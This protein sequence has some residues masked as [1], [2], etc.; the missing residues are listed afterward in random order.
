MEVIHERCAGLDVHKKTITAC[1]VHSRPKGRKEEETATFGTM[2]TELLRMGEWLLAWGCTHVA[3]ESTG[4]YWKP[5]YNILE[6]QME[7]LLVNAHHVKQVPGRKTDV[8][9]AGWLADLLRHGLLRGSFVPSRPQRELRDLTRQRSNLVREK[10]AVVNRLQKMLEDANIKLA[11]VVTDVTGVSARAMLE[12]IAAGEAKPNELAKLARGRLRKK[13]AEL[14]QALIGRVRDHHRFLLVTHLSHIDFLDEQIEQVNQRIGLHIERQSAL[15][16]GPSSEDGSG[17]SAELTRGER[18]PLT[19]ARAVDLLDTIP[20]ISRWL[21]ELIVAE[22]GIDMSRFPS[23]GHLSSWAGVAP[24]NNQSAGK[25]RSGKTPPG[26]RALRKGLVQAAQGAK[27]SKNTYLAAQYHRIAARRGKKRAS[28][29]VAHS[30]LVIAYYILS[31]QEPYRELGG[32]YFDERKRES[33]ANRLLRR[34]EKLGYQV[35]LDTKHV[36]VLAAA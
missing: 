20:G 18:G 22:M 16:P 6:G 9:D 24:G 36:G 3:M 32:N 19:Y 31:R 29:A 1:R 17:N 27:R 8:S 35:S 2:T 30:I 25:R 5:V 23:A 21:G 28:V 13:R 7:I 12:E 34:L 11:S 33:V 4:V 26:N 14:E 10:V 15:P